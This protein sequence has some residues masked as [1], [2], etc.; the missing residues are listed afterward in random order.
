MCGVI[1][2]DV[3]SFR[4]INLGRDA[5]ILIIALDIV[6]IIWSSINCLTVI[7]LPTVWYFSREA[8][9]KSTTPGSI[10]YHI[11]FP[12]YYLPL[13][14]SD[15]LFQ[16]PQNTLLHFLLLILLHVLSRSIL[17]NLHKFY[18]VNLTISGAVT[19]KGIDNPLYASGCK[20]LFFVCSYRLHSIAWF[21]YLIDTLLSWLREIPIVVVLHH[22]FLF[23]EIPT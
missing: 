21:S 5:Y 10:L 6:I 4:S 9:M 18:P 19:R 12:I 13:L 22:P 11:C 14:I 2:V 7:C 23:G 15:L 3:K 16:K 8:T 17:S 1:G 20:Y